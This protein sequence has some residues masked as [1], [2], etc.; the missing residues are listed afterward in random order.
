ME[1]VSSRI[2]T[3]VAEFV[4]YEDN[5]YTT[6]TSWITPRAPPEL[7]HGHLLLCVSVRVCEC[8]CVSEHVS[9][10]HTTTC[11]PPLSLSLS[12]YLS[13]YLSLSLSHIHTH[14][15]IYIYIY[16]W[17]CVCECVCVLICTRMCLYVSQSDNIKGWPTFSLMDLVGKPMFVEML[18]K[19]FT[20]KTYMAI[21]TSRMYLIHKIIQMTLNLLEKSKIQMYIA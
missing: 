12:L 16:I 6:G 18:K 19:I 7:H 17:V 15:Q 20:N 1:W 4:S 2:W 9:I 3:R 5:N 13:I 8:V 10:Q 14:T 21:S 11:I